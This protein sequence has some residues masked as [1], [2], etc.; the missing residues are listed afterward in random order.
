[1]GNWQGWEGLTP[2]WDEGQ[3]WENVRAMMKQEKGQGDT[4]GRK[5]RNKRERKKTHYNLLTYSK[6]FIY[7]SFS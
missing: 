5:F 6:L 4:E 3:L 7:I 1:M 2:N